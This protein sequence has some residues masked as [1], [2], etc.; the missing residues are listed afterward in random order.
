M[1]V[2]FVC[3]GNAFRSPVAEALLRKFKPEIEGDSAGTNP[4]IPISE[5]A[6]EYVEK[7]N[8]GEYLKKR[9]D[10]LNGKDLKRYELIVAMETRH[11]NAI[12]NRCPSCG[13]KIAVWHIE[14]PYFLPPGYAEKIFEKIKQK[15]KELADS[16]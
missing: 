11:R 5:A 7:E 15:V 12:L 9:P 1:K 4:V 3:S 14:D 13:D 16:M 2:L 8:A 10:D 6:R